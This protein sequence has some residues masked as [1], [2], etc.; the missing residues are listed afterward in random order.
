[1]CTEAH[2]VISTIR[3]EYSLNIMC[4]IFVVIDCSDPTTISNANVDYENTVINSSA[5]YTCSSGYAFLSGSNEATVMCTT[6]N[7]LTGI[8]T[9]E[10]LQCNS[11]TILFQIDHD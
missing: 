10:D 8:W 5:L 4:I 7:G 1:M 6:S 11:K 2:N 9:P 3:K